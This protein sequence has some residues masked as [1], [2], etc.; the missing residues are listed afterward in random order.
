MATIKS[1]FGSYSDKLQTIVD[2]S[3]DK[4]SPVWYP[5]YFTFGTPQMNLSYVSVLGSSRIE[6]A[7]SIIS[8]D[9]AAPL[10]SRAALNKLSGEIPAIAE[11]FKMSESD[12]RNFYAIQ[13]L[14][15]DESAKKQQLLDLLFG[16]VKKAGDS[17]HKKVDMMALEAVSTGSISIS[18]TNNP[19]GYVSSVPLDLGMPS[20]N[21]VNAAVNW[22]TSATA[23]PITD[24]QGIVETAEGSGKAF[25]KILMSR[26]VWLK[27]AAC[28]QVTDSLT[29]Y[30]Q[31]QKGAA[32]ATLARVNDYLDAMQLPMIEIV[33]EQIGVEKDG[34]IT[35]TK[36]F[37]QTNAVFVPAGPLGKIHNAL[38]MEQLQPVSNVSYAT[39]NRALISKWSDNE[40]FAEYTK[41]ELNA[42]PGFEAVENVYLLSTTVAY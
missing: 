18:V 24:I 31:L 22:S 29:S 2:T 16:D 28:K 34:T 1:V 15:L 14:P 27:F 5:K 4:F 8:R 21:K 36:P 23:T 40:P 42:F 38:A 10:R 7:A 13:Q 9:S 37:S 33:N 35:A 30:N 39:Y 19:D 32:V 26:A 20:G 3:L 25:S 17:A 41:V 11:K 6:A 12:Y